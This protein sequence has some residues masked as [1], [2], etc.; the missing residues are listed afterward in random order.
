[1]NSRNLLLVLTQIS[2]DGDDRPR[3]AL[4]AWD[5]RPA[6]DAHG[7]DNAALAQ[8]DAILR[9]FTLN[10]LRRAHTMWEPAGWMLVQA[11]D[12]AQALMADPLGCP[13]SEPG[14]QPSE[15]PRVRHEVWHA[16]RAALAWHYSIA[17]D[18]KAGIRLRVERAMR[19][20]A[21]SRNSPL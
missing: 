4:A 14:G 8:R 11:L 10:Y 21:V 15:R 1:M 9:E 20:V 17:K 2:P 6:V 12:Y 3:K 16:M 5:N 19:A 13:V 18:N 7:L